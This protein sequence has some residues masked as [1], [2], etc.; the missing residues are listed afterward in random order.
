MT[1]ESP[2][3]FSSEVKAQFLHFARTAR[4][5]WAELIIIYRAVYAINEIEFEARMAD[6]ATSDF[7]GNA[8]SL[9]NLLGRLRQ[10]SYR[11]GRGTWFSIELIVNRSGSITTHFNY[12]DEPCYD[13]PIPLEYYAKDFEE[14]P[15][16]EAF[17][18]EWLKL[19]LKL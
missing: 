16:S 13:L 10:N 17:V 7:C 5:K 15:R 11:S 14:F 2:L 19:K 12:D 9:I 8:R 3:D 4:D 18:P 1:A 6:G